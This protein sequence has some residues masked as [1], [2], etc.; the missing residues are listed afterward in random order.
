[1]ATIAR[2]F[3][4][5]VLTTSRRNLPE[6]AERVEL[7]ELL[8]RSHVVSLNSALT[9]ATHHIINEETL[10]LMRPDAIL[11]NTSRGA[12]VDED[13]LAAALEHGQIAAAAVDVLEEEPPRSGSPLIDTAQSVITPHVAWQSTE[14]R[15]RLLAISV[16]NLRAFLAGQPQNVVS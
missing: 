2:A 14:A 1:M 4:M 10:M 8:S 16:E 9:P 12:L 6:W 15:R 7:D 13:A 5:T 11:I 3:G